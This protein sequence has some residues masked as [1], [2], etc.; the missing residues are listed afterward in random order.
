VPRRL[1]SALLIGLSLVSSA[2][3]D[4]T[5]D[6]SDQ[7]LPSNSFNNGSNLAGGFTSNG[8]F[9]NNQYNT[10]Y[11][12]WGGW[13][14]SNVNAPTTPGFTNQYAAV[15]G[16]SPSGHGTYAVAFD[17]SPNAAYINL[18]NGTTPVSFEVTNTAYAYYSMLNG[19]QFAKQFA[20]GDSFT[21]QIAGYSGLNATGAKL[22]EVDVF[23]A[24]YLIDKDHPLNIWQTVQLAALGSAKSIGFTMASTD[25]GQYGINTPT[26]FA[27]DNLVVNTAAVP[28]PS[29]L[30][31]V[32][33]GLVG[34]VVV[35][36]RRRKNPLRA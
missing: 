25:V 11:G 21:L 5:I 18:P 19:D 16:T 23:L 7:P 20:L 28:E 14:L 9:F 3:A 29:S 32:A 2:R 27:L 35:G 12:S 17:S 1:A 10:T 22:D 34:L 15:T 36:S 30:V 8:A 6:F 26:F 13:S 33:T 24:N 31:L 4:F